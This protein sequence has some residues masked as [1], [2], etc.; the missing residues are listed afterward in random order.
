MYSP[1]EIT[2]LHPKLEIQKWRYLTIFGL[3]R[4]GWIGFMKAWSWIP[5][6]NQ[7]YRMKSSSP[8]CGAWNWLCTVVGRGSLDLP[9]LPALSL[10]NTPGASGRMCY[11]WMFKLKKFTSRW[12]QR[13]NQKDKRYFYNKNNLEWFHLF[14]LHRLAREVF[15]C[16]YN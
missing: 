9:N 11:L 10:N 8:T 7:C 3:R 15:V 16:Q 4:S 1:I 12:N 6:D 2:L 13:E 5:I 14:R